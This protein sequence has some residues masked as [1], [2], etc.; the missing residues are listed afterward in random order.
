MNKKLARTQFC[1][2]NMY[3]CCVKT[4]RKSVKMGGTLNKLYL[5]RVF[6]SKL[7]CLKKPF[8]STALTYAAQ[9]S[10]PA[11]NRTVLYEIVHCNARYDLIWY[12]Y[13]IS[14]IV[15]EMNSQRFSILNKQIDLYWNLLCWCNVLR[16]IRCL[17]DVTLSN[18]YGALSLSLMHEIKC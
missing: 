3:L 10:Q 4:W 7:K 15:W 12:F 8:E 6:D 5:V 14:S 18:C 9:R 17:C 13:V 2:Q 1:S 16:W 11:G